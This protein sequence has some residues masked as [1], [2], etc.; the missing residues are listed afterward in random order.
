MGRAEDKAGR[1]L[2]V[3]M[4][5]TTLEEN[6]EQAKLMKE[7]ARKHSGSRGDVDWSTYKNQKKETKKRK[8][9]AWVYD[10]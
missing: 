1:Q 6:R 9:T 4:D 2:G 5:V 7:E 3:F 10:P 8:A